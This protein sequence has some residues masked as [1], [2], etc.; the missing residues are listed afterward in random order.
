[1]G[2]GAVKVLSQGPTRLLSVYPPPR[3][4]P[5]SLPLCTLP[6]HSQSRV[7]VSRQGHPRL[8]GQDQLPA[9]SLLSSEFPLENTPEGGAL[10]PEKAF[11]SKKARLPRTWF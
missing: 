8:P 11:L 2:V 4:Q 10:G 3:P 1:M 9:F 5:H 6:L 7:P